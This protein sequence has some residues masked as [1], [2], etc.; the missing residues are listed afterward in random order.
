MTR[1]DASIR[2]SGGAKRPVN[3]S[4]M[5]TVDEIEDKGKDDYTDKKGKRI[6]NISGRSPR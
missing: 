5:E 2:H 6:M 1:H 4:V 3:G